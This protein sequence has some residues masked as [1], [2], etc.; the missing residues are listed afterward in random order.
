M[1]GRRARNEA[2]T[3]SNVSSVSPKI[4]LALGSMEDEDEMPGLESSVDTG[5]DADERRKWLLQGEEEDD[6]DGDDDEAMFRDVEGEA[7]RL[8]AERERISLLGR[9]W[10]RRLRRSRR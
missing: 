4:N 8:K 9:C 5:E 3:S 1:A 2:F 6:D 10:I 7:E